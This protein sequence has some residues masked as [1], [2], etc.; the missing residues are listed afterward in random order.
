MKVSDYYSNE[1]REND[2]EGLDYVQFDSLVGETKEKAKAVTV[3]AKK[4][5]TKKDGTEACFLV[6]KGGEYTYTESVAVVKLMQKVDRNEFGEDPFK[7]V[8]FKKKSEKTGKSYTA[9]EDA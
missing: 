1:E 2:F 3:M 7:V 4:S 9:V 5:I 6:L 8:F